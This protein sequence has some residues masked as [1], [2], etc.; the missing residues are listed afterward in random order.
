MASP[1]SIY[2]PPAVLEL[3]V[4]LEFC[5]V[6]VTSS[7]VFRVLRSSRSLDGLTHSRSAVDV[8]ERDSGVLLAAVQ[9]CLELTPGNN[10]QR[11]PPALLELF[12][13]LLLL[14]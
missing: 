4:L 1:G 2:D 3:Q 11:Y 6:N 7:G 10:V 12:G 13:P 14:L 8:Q 9:R 5:T